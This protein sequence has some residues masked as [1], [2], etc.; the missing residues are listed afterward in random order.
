MSSSVAPVHSTQL[1]ALSSERVGDIRRHLLEWY[2]REAR[3]LPWRVPSKSFDDTPYQE[4][5]A[6]LYKCLLSETMLQQTQVKT[7]IAYYTKWLEKFPTLE[8]LAV[9]SEED[10]MACWAGLGYYSRAKRLQQAAQY[11]VSNYVSAKLEFPRSPEYWIKNVPGVGPY[12]AG[13]ILSIAF[14]IP[15]AIVD[16]NVQRVLSRILAVHGDTS[17]PKAPGTKILWARAAQLVEG[18]DPG[19]LNQSL[20]ELGA[21][22]CS[23]TLPNCSLCPVKNECLAF[24]QFQRL[25]SSRKDFFAKTSP[26]ETLSTISSMNSDMEDLCT[27]C[28]PTIDPSVL[29]QNP[30][31]YIQSLYPFKPQRKAQRE[32]TAMVMVIT[33][34]DEVYLEKKAKGLLA[35]LFDFPTVLLDSDAV[36]DCEAIVERHKQKLSATSMGTTLHLFTHIRRTSHVLLCRHETATRALAAFAEANGTG[37]WVRRE[38]IEATGV[39][40]LCLKNWRLAIGTTKP[41][42]RRMDQASASAGKVKVKSRKTPSQDTKVKDDG[43]SESSDLALSESGTVVRSEV[44]G[45]VEPPRAPLRQRSIF[46]MFG[47]QSKR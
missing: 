3:V 19:H 5:V 17:T 12:T 39:S 45:L 14:G 13:A 24:G 43:G 28:P 2:E 11:L 33:K 29:P 46:T 27:V 6:R 26:A 18:R 9:A 42:K 15:S 7:V 16:G 37:K 38:A 8:E 25:R 30:D 32:E 1:H 36:P 23:P 35:G 20:M 4:Y 31:T 34:D 44:T 41:K 10:V 40:E 22:V 47:R 21:T